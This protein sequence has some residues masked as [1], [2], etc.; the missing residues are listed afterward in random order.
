MFKFYRNVLLKVFYKFV[1]IKCI[2]VICRILL[3][4]VFVCY[5]LNVFFLIGVN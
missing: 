2:G 5:L 4:I 1:R 3:E